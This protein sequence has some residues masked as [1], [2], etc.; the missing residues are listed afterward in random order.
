[1]SVGPSPSC[2]S[3]CSRTCSAA[4]D[5]TAAA[6]AARTSSLSAVACSASASGVVIRSRVVSALSTLPVYFSADTQ[7]VPQVVVTVWIFLSVLIAVL[8][9]RTHTWRR[10]T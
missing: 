9:L 10:P 2:S 5:S 6:R 1:M 3:R 7:G 4:A 8:L